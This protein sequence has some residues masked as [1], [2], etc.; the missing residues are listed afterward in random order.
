MKKILLLLVLAFA[1]LQF[2]QIDKIN[3]I[4]DQKNDFLVFKNTPQNVATIIKS[5]CYDCHSNETIYPWYTNVQPFGWFLKDHI[6]EG[7]KELNF[8][9]F[10]TYEPSKQTKK[11]DEAIEE[12][13]KG[14][15]PLDTY[16]II[17]QNAKLTEEQKQIL[18]SYFKQTKAT[19]LAENKF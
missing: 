19:I 18:V 6:D 15:M 8:S 5:A 13:Q 7:R 12:V 4:V 2:F 17:H 1:L 14:E 11:L 16:T 9:T 3:P 10:A